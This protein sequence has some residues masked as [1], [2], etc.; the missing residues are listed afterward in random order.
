[1]DGENGRAN[2]TITTIHFKRPL[3]AYRP[4]FRDY[5]SYRKVLV[6]YILLV[7][8]INKHQIMLSYIVSIADDRSEG[9]HRF[10]TLTGTPSCKYTPLQ[11]LLTHQKHTFIGCASRVTLNIVS[12]S[13]GHV[14]HY[15]YHAYLVWAW[16]VIPWV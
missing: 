16:L 9:L 15:R 13:S 7:H 3:W 2:Q 11:G 14:I 10:Y 5:Q 1:M 12:A 6:K 8:I 4:P